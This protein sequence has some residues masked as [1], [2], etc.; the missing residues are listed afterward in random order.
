VFD[1]QDTDT[2]FV[3]DFID[4]RWTGPRRPTVYWATRRLESVWLDLD[5]P[6]FYN[7]YQLSGNCFNRLSALEGQR[8][9]LVV[10]AYEI[11]TAR[12]DH[13][14]AWSRELADPGSNV[15][16]AGWDFPPPTQAD[17]DRLIQEP[18]VDLIVL[19]H[20]YPGYT[21]TNGRLFIYDARRLRG[22]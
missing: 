3:R 6:C 21:A 17:F 20:E 13:D 18:A 22:K 10:R 2:R 11:E 15:F 19:P 5:C 4:R 9:A 12:R 1:R 14:L 16:N 7:T 8:R